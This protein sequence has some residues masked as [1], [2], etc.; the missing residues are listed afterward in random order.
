MTLK[1][2]ETSFFTQLE[3]VEFYNHPLSPELKEKLEL[4]VTLQKEVKS[5]EGTNLEK[6]L[7][8]KIENLIKVDQE[9]YTNSE[10][11]LYLNSKQVTEQVMQYI[12]IKIKE[13][14]G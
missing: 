10:Y 6:H 1:D 14:K 5:L 8:H 7:K 11:R 2:L 13:L 12:D 9:L 3:S 4:Q